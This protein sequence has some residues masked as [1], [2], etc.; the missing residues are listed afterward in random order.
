MSNDQSTGKSNSNGTL[1]ILRKE[2]IIPILVSVTSGI[3]LLSYQN[4]LS[5]NNSSPTNTIDTTQQIKGPSPTSDPKEDAALKRAQAIEK[6]KQDL[7]DYKENAEQ[8]LADR[9]CDQA[10][11]MISK[12]TWPSPGLDENRRLAI[13]YDRVRK[14]LADRL[15]FCGIDAAIKEVAEDTKKEA[16]RKIKSIIERRYSDMSIMENELIEAP[17]SYG[18]DLYS[19]TYRYKI[20]GQ[21]ANGKNTELDATIKCGIPLID[22]KPGTPNYGIPHIAQVGQ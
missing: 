5:N 6:I 2:L 10:K 19:I 15:T 8:L 18:D 20:V 7:A 11:E 16:L 22:G 12:I 14:E 21:W 3:A 9:N 1:S 17:D 13:Q 4:F